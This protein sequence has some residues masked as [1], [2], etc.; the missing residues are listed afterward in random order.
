MAHWKTLL[1]YGAA[2][3]A[4]TLLLQALDFTALARLH[5]TDTYIALIACAFLGLGVYLGARLF[6]P[7]PLPL[8]PGNP[9]ARAALGISGR[10]LEV[11]NEVAAGYSNKE[12]AIRL[13]LSPNTV[14]THVA[15]L[16]E[17]LEARRRT[18]AIHK[19]RAL[20]IVA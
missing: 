5:A 20:G 2:L 8:P 10:E 6:R 14:K 19:A 13:G 16:L 4:G 3:A 7:A 17:K 1:V 18:E 11:L 12:I 15:R 9:A